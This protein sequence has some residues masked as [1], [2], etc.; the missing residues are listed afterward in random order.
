MHFPTIIALA[1][2]SAA[3]CYTIPDVFARSNS[4]LKGSAKHAGDS[5]EAPNYNAQACGPGNKG[6][7]VGFLQDPISDLSVCCCGCGAVVLTHSSPC[8]SC[9]SRTRMMTTTT[10]RWMS[11]ASPGLVVDATS[12]SAA[13]DRTKRHGE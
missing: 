4:C 9:V 11:G 12:A 8:S 2:A 13:W 7:V 5:C 1:M 6:N 10:G 3:S